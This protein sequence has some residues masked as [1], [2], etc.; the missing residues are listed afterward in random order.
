MGAK[1]GMKNYL[2]SYYREPVLSDTPGQTA[3]IIS[4]DDWD[5]IVE[6][7]TTVAPC[8]APVPQ[9]QAS[10]PAFPQ[11]SS[12]IQHAGARLA[13]AGCSPARPVLWE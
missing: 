11:C 6:Y 2:G 10:V 1:L 13:G 12:I 5:K 9:E 7:Y 3:S 4:R 8:E